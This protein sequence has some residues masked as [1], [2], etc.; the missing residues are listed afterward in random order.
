MKIKV[1]FSY[2]YLLLTKFR[3]L[4]LLFNT[5]KVVKNRLSN[6]YKPKI[7]FKLGSIS[8]AI[9]VGS[10]RIYYKKRLIKIYHPITIR[11]D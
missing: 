2:T 1:E 4:G 8:F 6:H 5:V 3:Q 10:S 7:G 11:S 9:Y